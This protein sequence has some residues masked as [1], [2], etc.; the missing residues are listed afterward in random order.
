MSINSLIIST[1]KPANVP[2]AFQVYTGAETTYIT[3]FKVIDVPKLH[4]E[5]KLK[6]TQTMI[7]VDVWSKG[8]IENLVTTVEN[9]ME[10]AGF[11]YSSGRDLYE[12]DTKTY[13][14]AL[15][16]NYKNKKEN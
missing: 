6:A 1:L 8:N 7:Q 15:T 10:A 12:K 2:I 11:L 9:L 13:H 16:Y 5:N 3:F 4:A 14:Y